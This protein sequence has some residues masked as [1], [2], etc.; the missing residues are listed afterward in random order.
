[1]KKRD[2]KKLDNSVQWKFKE[3]WIEAAE[4]DGFRYISE[5]L[6][7][8]I[9]Q[10]IRLTNI[11]NKVGV[12]Y[13]AINNKLNKLNISFKSRPGGANNHFNRRGIFFV[14]VPHR[15]PRVIFVTGK[16]KR[17]KEKNKYLYHTLR[18]SECN[19]I[20]SDETWI[21]HEQCYELIKRHIN[22]GCEYDLI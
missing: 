18:C 9:T 2:W 5:W 20:L 21:T 11:A 3:S 7:S 13:S 4:Q 19:E 17:A 15:R 16:V 1:M 22:K 12:T 10:G 6:S 14:P 8:Q